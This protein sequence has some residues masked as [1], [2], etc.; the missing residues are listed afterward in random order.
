MDLPPRLLVVSFSMRKTI[1]DIE[2]RMGL[3]TFKIPKGTVVEAILTPTDRFALVVSDPLNAIP[4]VKD[5]PI[6][7]HDLTHYYLFVKKE[8]TEES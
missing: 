4:A 8:M 7:R 5:N 3:T 6:L 2:T 1:Q